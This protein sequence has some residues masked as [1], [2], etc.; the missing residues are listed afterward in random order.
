[1]PF[2]EKETVKEIRKEIKATFPGMKFS[3]RLE[4]HTSICVALM[5]GKVE[6]EKGNI[7]LNPYYLERMENEELK[8]IFIKVKEIINSH[9]EQKEEQY[10]GDYGSI[11]SF[12]I[13]LEVGR[14]DRHYKKIA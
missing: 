4:D 2:I 14:W 3:V 1:M 10:D 8:S 11:P 6:V 13:N 5:E 7:Q 9:K 12:Y